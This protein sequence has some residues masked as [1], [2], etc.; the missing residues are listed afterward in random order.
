[1]PVKK[2]EQKVFGHKI[3]RVMNEALSNGLKISPHAASEIRQ[4]HEAHAKHWARYPRREGPDPVSTI[5]TFEPY[6]V[7]L[8]FRRARRGP[9]EDAYRGRRHRRAAKRG[10]VYAHD[11][12]ERSVGPHGFPGFPAWRQRRRRYG[13][14]RRPYHV[15][16]P[17]LVPH[18]G[19]ILCDLYGVDGTPHPFST[20]AL[21]RRILAQ[22][23]ERSLTWRAGLEVEF[24]V[25]KL[26]EGSR[27]KTTSRCRGRRQK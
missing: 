19:W 12:V 18:S 4:L 9:R 11:A 17:A 13:H 24:H 3:D 22:L 7:E 25:L 6:A 16:G 2:L 1:V 8:L 23:D 14:G 20:R 10:H 27:P 15:P 26:A 5:D 21:M